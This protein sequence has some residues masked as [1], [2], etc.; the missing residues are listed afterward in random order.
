MLEKT[1]ESPLGGKEI[2]PANSKGNQPW[3][4][5]GR[6]IAEA[7]APVLWPPN[8]KNW[9]IGKDP[10][11][12]KDWR[13]KKKWAAEDEMAKESITDSIDMNLSKLWEIVDDWMTE[14]PGALQSM[15]LQRVGY[16]LATEL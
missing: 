5:I 9:L 4:F 6:T 16:D 3:I 8:S 2:K 15:A 11:A 13:Q 12:G 1:L 10:N 7:E 14:E